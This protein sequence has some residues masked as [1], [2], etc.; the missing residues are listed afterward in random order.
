VPAGPLRFGRPP[1]AELLALLE[2]QAGADVTY[3]EVGASLGDLP[4]G[5]HH[6][7]QSVVLGPSADTFAAGADALRRW[8]GHAH[9][10]AEVLPRNAPLVVGR[11]V[12][13]VL[14]VGPLTSLAACRVVATV[15]EPGRFG[16]AYGTLPLHPVSG[17]ESF[18][19]ERTAEGTIRFSIAAFSR[20]AALLARLGTPVARLVQHRTTTAYLEG[21]RS[22]CR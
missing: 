16:F 8:A 13:L 17:E 19:I 12:L 15:D 11:D 5:Y 3:Q 7:R 14:A 20:Q 2:A 22:A 6:H 1:P 4:P 21:V 9:A 18:L 10:G